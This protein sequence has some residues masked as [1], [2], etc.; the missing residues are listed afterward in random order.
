VPNP[1]MASIRE[2]SSFM[3]LALELDFGHQAVW[4][5]A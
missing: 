5:S 2:A 4:Q 1:V 3:A